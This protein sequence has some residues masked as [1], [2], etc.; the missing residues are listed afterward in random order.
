MVCRLPWCGG[1]ALLRYMCAGVL[2][3]VSFKKK[4]RFCSGGG[5]QEFLVA[6]FNYELQFFTTCS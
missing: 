5:S 6:L 1:V 2:M 3:K 4:K